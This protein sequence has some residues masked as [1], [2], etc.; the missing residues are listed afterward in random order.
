MIRRVL[1][2]AVVRASGLRI[3]ALILGIA[4]SIVV[5]R[6][7][8][9]ELKGVASAFAAANALAFSFINLDLGHQVLRYGRET[10]RLTAVGPLL[11][12]GW[13]LYLALGS[14]A[15][16]IAMAVSVPT[17]WL[18]IGAIA[19]LIGNQASV[20]ATGLRGAVA[21]AWGAVIQ[22]LA[23]IVGAVLL[24]SSGSFT[25]E[26]VKYVVV[27]SY[28]CPLL[29]YAFFLWRGPRGEVSAGWWELLR[30]AWAGVPWQF[31]RLPQML[32]LKLDVVV[33]FAVVGAA[34]A[35][36]YSVGLSLAMLCTIIPSQF[37]ASALHQATR[38]GDS[39]PG[40]NMALAAVSGIGTATLLAVAGVP[41]ITL[42]YG[43]EFDGAYAVMLATLAGACSYGVMQVQSNYIRILGTGRQLIMTNVIGLMV[44]LVGFAVL[45]PPLAEVGA[46][47]AFSFGCTATA[48]FTVLMRKRYFPARPAD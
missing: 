38:G 25:E 13:A 48:L 27:A 14:I 46:G 8:G 11:A 35:G 4:A 44:M 18:V 40:R 1:G 23:M 32:L 15:A 3:L 34:A 36:I 43:A 47:L 33:V 24:A 5:A 6:L 16:I 7:G 29:Y 28:L 12:R 39:R 10:G 42:L 41:A 26:T 17:V 30:L 20:A 9:A 21:S 31:A 2:H 37:A 45:V 19:F 22:Q